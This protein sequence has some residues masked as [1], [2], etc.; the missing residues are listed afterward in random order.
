MQAYAGVMLDQ[1]H[2]TRDEL[3]SSASA[4]MVLTTNELDEKSGRLS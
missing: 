1:Y 2:A 4:R 3:I